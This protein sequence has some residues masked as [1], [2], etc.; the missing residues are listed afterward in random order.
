M[1]LGE[2]IK[3]YRS[4]NDISQ[5]QFALRCNISNGYISMLEE[6]KRPKTNE[7]VVPTINTIRKI[8]EAMGMSAH[9]LIAIVDDM[10]INITSSLNDDFLK[11]YS[12]H[13]IS[14]KKLPLLG[15]VACGE[16]ILAQQNI[17]DYINCPENVDAT[18]CLRCKGDSMIGARI[19]DGDIVYIHQQPTIENGEIAAVLIDNEA[20]LK[21]VY[22][23]A[24]K[25]ILQPE[26]PAYPPLVF[27]REEINQIRILGKAV[28]F[29]SS[30]K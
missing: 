16:P 1:K 15:N 19:H 3:Q 28:C 21:R 27:V 7:P 6:G 18:F 11:K 14:K 30:I 20:T 13:T 8:A 22:R 17:E 5:R 2:F 4:E 29:L 26:N 12:L 25:V 10:P 24:D 9:E 23:Q